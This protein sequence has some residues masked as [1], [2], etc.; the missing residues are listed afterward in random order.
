VDQSDNE[1]GFEI[2]RTS[3]GL[4]FEVIAITPANA[5]S[6]VNKSLKPRIGYAYRIRAVGKT[7]ASAWSAVRLSISR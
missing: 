1:I 3:G 4:T 7:G 2:Q 5:T 6:F